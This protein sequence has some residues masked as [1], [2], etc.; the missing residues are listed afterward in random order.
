MAI[1]NERIYLQVDFA[2]KDEVKKQGAFWDPEQKA[3][4]VLPGRDLGPFGPWLPAEALIDAE[5]AA[6]AHREASKKPCDKCEGTGRYARLGVEHGK[7]YTCGGT[8]QVPALA[9]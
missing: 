8:G 6:P 3:W 4:F 2:D 9:A 1:R 5:S 7:C